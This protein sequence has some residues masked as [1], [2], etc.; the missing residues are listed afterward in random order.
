MTNVFDL[1][2]IKD[3]DY[4]IPVID[5]RRDF[6]FAG[7]YDKNLITAKEIVGKIE[8]AKETQLKIADKKQIAEKLHLKISQLKT[9]AEQ[10]KNK[11]DSEQD[12]R[13]AEKLKELLKVD[14]INKNLAE[15]IYKTFH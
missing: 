14:G 9:K 12:F 13:N 2:K 8:T 11:I 5:A 6:F 10:I 3:K 4:I 15:K 1:T 7:I